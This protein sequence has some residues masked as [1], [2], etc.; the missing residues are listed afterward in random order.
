M[1]SIKDNIS[2][3][4][5]VKKSKFISKLYRINSIEETMSILNKLK[6]EYNDSTHI[7]YAY[8]KYFEK[9]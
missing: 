3:I 7:C 2:N 1:Y 4:Q 6:S 8:F 5:E 9:K